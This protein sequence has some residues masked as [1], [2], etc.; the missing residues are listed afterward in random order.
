MVHFREDMIGRRLWLCQQNQMV[1]CSHLSG[2]DQRGDRKQGLAIKYQ[3]LPHSDPL[4]PARLHL[5][6][7]LINV[8]IMTSYRLKTQCELY[9]HGELPCLLHQWVAQLANSAWP[10]ERTSQM[11][12]EEDTMLS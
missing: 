2:T 3:G 7:G 12:P 6:K 1:T 9:S 10:T 11:T 8:Q 5:P 4:P